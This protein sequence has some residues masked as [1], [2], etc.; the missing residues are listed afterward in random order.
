MILFLASRLWL[1]VRLF[2]RFSF[3]Y[4]TSVSRCAFNGTLVILE[5][6]HAQTIDTLTTRQIH[7]ERER[8]Q[9]HT[10]NINALIKFHGRVLLCDCISSLVSILSLSLSLVRWLFLMYLIWYTHKK[11]KQLSHTHTLRYMKHSVLFF[12]IESSSKIPTFL[13]ESKAERKSVFQG[14]KI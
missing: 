10:F 3:S 7:T 12:L 9:K 13:T 4:W 8:E 14:I 2:I 11:N 5:Q 6:K 1:Y